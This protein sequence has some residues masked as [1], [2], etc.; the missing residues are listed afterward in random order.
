MGLSNT[1]VF[2]R[3]REALADALAGSLV[4]AAE[5]WRWRQEGERLAPG[6]IAALCLA[7]PAADQASG[8]PT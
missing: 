7:G 2:D 3:A 1:P 5:L 4:A 6:E 8:S